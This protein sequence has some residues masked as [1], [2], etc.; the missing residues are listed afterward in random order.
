MPASHLVNIPTLKQRV[1]SDTG[2]QQRWDCDADGSLSKGRTDRRVDG[3]REKD[4]TE[5][6]RQQTDTD[7]DGDRERDG[8]RESYLCQTGGNHQRGEGR[9]ALSSI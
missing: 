8:E 7:G 4:E 3:Q 6:E 2:P 9:M 1:S 5:R